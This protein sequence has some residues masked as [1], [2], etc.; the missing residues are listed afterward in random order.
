M[1][2]RFAHSLGVCHVA[3]KLFDAIYARDAEILRSEYGYEPAGRDRQRQI[4]RLAALMHDLGHAPFSHAAEHLFPARE[5]KNKRYEH[6]DYSVSIAVN[7]LK[8]IL[9]SSEINKRNLRITVEEVV[10]FFDPASTSKDSLVW[11]D[12]ISGQMDADRM[13]YL[14]RD[15]YHAGVTYGQY[16]LSRLIDTVCLCEDDEVG[17]HHVG[18]SEAGYH[19]VEG[20]LIARYMMFTQVYFHKTR[21]IYDFHFGEALRYML[22]EDSYCFPTPL[23]ADIDRYMRWD[24]WRVLAALHAGEGG[25]HGQR[26]VDRNHYRLC[27]YTAEIPTVAEVDK[28]EEIVK[29]IPHGIPLQVREANKSWYKLGGNEIRVKLDD[30]SSMPLAAMSPVVD[31]LKSVNQKRL[32]V[33]SEHRDDLRKAIAKMGGIS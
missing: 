4:I 10:S 29:G 19:A 26:I 5:G 12:L 28:F 24:D 21:V 13:G 14:L 11:K 8:D 1:H 32:Y 20:L 31:G 17:G 22:S 2:T 15:G 25:E 3:T 16:D 33:P 27:H 23:P 18:V 6:E 9:D 7:L 30:G